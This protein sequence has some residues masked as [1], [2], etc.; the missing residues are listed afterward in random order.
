MPELPNEP[1]PLV[2]SV[3][4][5][6]VASMDEFLARV[7]IAN[8]EF[9]SFAFRTWGRQEPYFTYTFPTTGNS[10]ATPCGPTN[11][12]TLMYCPASDGVYVSTQ[13]AYDL[14][15]GAQFGG[16]PTPGFQ[17]ADFGVA[18]IVG[19]EIAHNIQNELGIFPRGDTVKNHELQADCLSGIWARWAYSQNQLDAGDL[20][21]A[22]EAAEW[23]G[24]YQN[25]N[26]QHHGLPSE[27]SAAWALG[28]NNYSMATCN[29]YNRP[30]E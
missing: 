9:W 20:E 3:F 8:D 13:A 28:F 17:P 5:D 16:G 26:Q 22:V 19:H 23:G 15:T 24:D 1:I 21:E 29:V 30:S 25:T 4:D 10:I 14:W 12:T 11:D 6:G 27:R 7:V 2:S 18:Y